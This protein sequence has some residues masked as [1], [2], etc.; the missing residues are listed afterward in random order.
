MINPP[1]QFTS[2]QVR[3]QSAL[4]REAIGLGIEKHKVIASRLKGSLLDRTLSDMFEQEIVHTTINMMKTDVVIGKGDVF[5]HQ[6][7]E[8]SALILIDSLQSEG[9]TEIV[10]DK[11][12]Q[13]APLGN[14]LGHNK[15]ASLSLFEES[16][17][18]LGTCIAPVGNA[19]PGDDVLKIT[20]ETGGREEYVIKQG[21]FNI[22]PIRDREVG[23]NLLPIRSDLGRGRNKT[24]TRTVR[25]GCLG[26]II[27]T[28]DRPIAGRGRPLGLL[29]YQ[30]GRTL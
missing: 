12:S 18:L 6:S 27:D 4:A 21:E 1:E 19:K 26:L 3:I 7:D 9:I 25:G 15:E 16:I 28:R 13:A 11:S 8:E 23:M 20:L 2:E 30:N 10:L 17:S 29:P 14:L 5:K 24:V 22:L